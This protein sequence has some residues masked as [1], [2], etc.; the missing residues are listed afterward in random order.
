[1]FD[2]VLTHLGRTKSARTAFGTSSLLRGEVKPPALRCAPDGGWQRLKFWMLA[3]APME[4]APPLSE[5]PAVR[6][7]F[8][9]CLAGLD[10]KDTQELSRRIDKARS[11]RELWYLRAPLFGHL[12]RHLSQAEAQARLETLNPHF[13]GRAARSALA[14]IN[15]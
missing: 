6:A 13:G 1:M 8:R 10:D 5:L 4:A 7:G 2:Q 15:P 12:A 9:A 14:Q 11:L 3:P